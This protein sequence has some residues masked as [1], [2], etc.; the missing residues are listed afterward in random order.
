MKH[1]IVSF[2]CA[3]FQWKNIL[4]FWAL[5]FLKL[6]DK[7]I[8]VKDFFISTK[9]GLKMKEHLHQ[10]EIFSWDPYFNRISIKEKFENGHVQDTNMPTYMIL[11]VWDT[12][13][14][15]TWSAKS[16]IK[17]RSKSKIH[18]FTIYVKLR[19][20]PAVVTCHFL[21]VR[22]YKKWYWKRKCNFGL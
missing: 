4:K 14:K 17:R 3:F 12:I 18:I 13:K 9:V 5:K 2:S 6:K 20:K 7:S 8:F 16:L 1:W 15:Y 21:M 22:L 10:K 11:K 19:L